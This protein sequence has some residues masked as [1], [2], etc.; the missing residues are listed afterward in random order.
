MIL[1]VAMAQAMTAQSREVKGALA[2][3]AMKPHGMGQT[4]DWVMYWC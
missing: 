3:D 4:L 1:I 2:C